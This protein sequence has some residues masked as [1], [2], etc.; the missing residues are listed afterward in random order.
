MEKVIHFLPPIVRTFSLWGRLIKAQT[1][2]SRLCV[3]FLVPNHVFISRYVN[4]GKKWTFIIKWMGSSTYHPSTQFLNFMLVSIAVLSICG[5]FHEWKNI[6]FA[7][8]LYNS[9]CN[10]NILFFDGII[11][12]KSYTVM[13]IERFSIIEQ[14]QRPKVMID[15]SNNFFC[16]FCLVDKNFHNTHT[17]TKFSPNSLPSSAANFSVR[18]IL[19]QCNILILHFFRH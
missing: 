3:I 1:T 7:K 4:I 5:P 17:Y 15:C 9:V 8:I 19:R 14:P 18:I 10:V 12:R 13:Y 2:K 6:Y 11:L 16:L